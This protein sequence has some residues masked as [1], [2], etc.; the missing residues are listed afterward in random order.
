MPLTRPATGPVRAGAPSGTADPRSA[1]IARGTVAAAAA[2]LALW[3]AL[4]GASLTR[5]P[6]FWDESFY[7]VQAHTGLADPG[8]RWDPLF[9]AKG[10]LHNW[11]TMVI[12]WVGFSPLTAV[13]LVSMGAGLATLAMVAALGRRLGGDVTALVA[14][15][16]YAIAPIFVVHDTIGVSD[17]LVAAATTGALLAAIRLAERPVPARAAA[18]GLVLG[19][20]LLVKVSAGFAV[21]AAP[22][23]VL[24]T[25]ERWRFL[26]AVA[27]AAAVAVALLQLQ[28]LSP[29]YAEASRFA[30][31]AEGVVYR[32]P[33]EVLSDP[34]RYLVDATR[35]YARQM[36]SWF[37]VPLIVAVAVGLVSVRRGAWR[38]PVLLA[39]WSGAAAMSVALLAPV[40]WGRY[41]LASIPPLL[42]LA[43]L[44]LVVA[45]RW[46]LCRP[47]GPILVALGASV[48]LAPPLLFDGRFAAHPGRPAL[49]SAT[50][51]VVY[52][53]GGTAGV[54]WDDVAGA[55]RGEMRRRP[56][57]TLAYG[58]GTPWFLGVLLGD[59][60]WVGIREGGVRHETF[61]VTEGAHRMVVEPADRSKPGRCDLYLWDRSAGPPPARAIDGMARALVVERPD[62]GALELYRRRGG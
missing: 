10:P 4:R 38:L 49:P 58:T 26:A 7:A 17:P 29:D 32:A 20:A 8:R 59:P 19:F 36:A 11:M 31:W 16:L 14:A 57:T 44:G 23:A 51:D 27:G 22:L 30:G 48:A 9:D 46:A 61:T 24:L 28:R 3:G 33:S 12:D 13:R 60:F 53:T 25:R 43:A 39:A 41:L 34:V 15:A 62:M 35:Q 50:D 1:P 45:A 37:S 21:I 56:L 54:G 18:L 40:L 5:F 2:I 42:A 55:L 47:G 6:P 52:R